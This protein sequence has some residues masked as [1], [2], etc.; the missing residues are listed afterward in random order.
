MRN[1]LRLVSLLLLAPACSGSIQSDGDYHGAESEEGLSSGGTVGDKISASCTTASVAGLSHQIAAEIGCIAPGTLE[2]FAAT[3]GIRFTSSAVLPYLHPD[4]VRA[5]QAAAAQREVDLNSAF[6]TVAQQY[7][8]YRWYQA[9]RCGIP[10]AA[11]PGT[12]NHESARAID[13]ADWSGDLSDL[14]RHGW[15]HDVPGDVVHF[16][17]L[18]SA[19]LR[20][21]D[22]HAFQRLWNRNHPGDRIAEDGAYGPQTG[23]RL[24]RSP[25]DG[26]AIGAC[27]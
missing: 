7:L 20:G 9:G 26:F 24:E 23:A 16:E 22:V 3:G 27:K 5:L 14:E 18:A 11:S 10:I 21:L 8:L 12:S 6:R 19:D 17:H 15:S 13:V 4:A 2:R 25:A 1:M